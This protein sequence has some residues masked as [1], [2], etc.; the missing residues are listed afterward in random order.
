MT[1]TR[2]HSSTG[3]WLTVALV[4]VLVGYPLSMGPFVLIAQSDWFPES[5]WIAQAAEYFCM[6][7]LWLTYNSPYPVNYAL[8]FYVDLWK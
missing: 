7:Y 4:A 2:K 1:S 3:F 8:V 5:G 6:P